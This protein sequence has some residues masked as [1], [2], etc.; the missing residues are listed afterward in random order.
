MRRMSE[1]LKHL[2]IRAK[3]LGAIIDYYEIKERDKGWL[4][5][6]DRLAYTLAVTSLKEV[7]SVVAYI[8]GE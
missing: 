4:T 5:A 8:E 6:D 2:K 3:A 7:E 1:I